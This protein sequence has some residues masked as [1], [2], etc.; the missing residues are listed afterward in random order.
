MRLVDGNEPKQEVSSA[1]QASR[2][3]LVFGSVRGVALRLSRH[4]GLKQAA[5]LITYCLNLYKKGQ[6]FEIILLLWT[7]RG[8]AR[9]F[10]ILRSHPISLISFFISGLAWPH[11][12]SETSA[13]SIAAYAG[14]PGRIVRRDWSPS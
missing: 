10:R 7:F 1:S 9:E 14:T 11:S 13:I 6:A 12:N 8:K 5:S 4:A 3:N 2:P